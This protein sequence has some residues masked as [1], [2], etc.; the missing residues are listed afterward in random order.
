METWSMWF[1]KEFQLSSWKTDSEVCLKG[2]GFMIGSL[3]ASKF[4]CFRKA[5]LFNES[6]VMGVVMES[7][8]NQ[9]E[10]RIISEDIIIWLK[11]SSKSTE[12][13]LWMEKGKGVR[14]QMPAIVTGKFKNCQVSLWL[15]WR[16]N[17]TPMNLHM[18]SP[19][20]PCHAQVNHFTLQNYFYS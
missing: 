4:S 16:S 6:E 18:V 15:M 12:K 9:K 17:I 8:G 11:K 7:Y 19:S 20:L 5:M 3:E 1:Y 13:L 2:V 10:S 14:S